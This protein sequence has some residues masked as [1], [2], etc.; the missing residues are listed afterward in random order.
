MYIYPHV[1]QQAFPKQSPTQENF[2]SEHPQNQRQLHAE[3]QIS[4]K[5]TQQENTD[6]RKYGNQERTQLHEKRKPS[7]GKLMP[8]H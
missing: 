7:I 3:H 8:V 4:D 1:G 2:Q 6:N 5:C